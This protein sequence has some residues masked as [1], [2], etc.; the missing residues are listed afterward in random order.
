MASSSNSASGKSRPDAQTQI[1]ALARRAVKSVSEKKDGRSALC[2]ASCVA[3]AESLCRA[4]IELDGG[5]ADAVLAELTG[6]GFG[7]DELAGRIIPQAARRLGEMW[8][9]DEVTFPEV[10]MAA[11]RMQAMI[12]DLFDDNAGS[13][14]DAPRVALIVSTAE[15]HTLGAIVVTG[16]MRRVGV[17]V[18]LCLGRPVAE[19][20]AMLAGSDVDL[21]MISAASLEALPETGRVLRM[22]REELKLDVP[23][24]VG[25][26]VL[27]YA[28]SGQGLELADLVTIDPMDALMRFGLVSGRSRAEA[29]P[30]TG[31]GQPQGPG[32]ALPGDNPGLPVQ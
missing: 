31:Q 13:E 29:A 20:R 12:R 25:G 3:A 14:P 4:A 7:I 2:D 23:L 11:A 18:D 10:S 32:G 19:I 16:M 22:I 9:E 17:Q 26:P 28:R 30:E 27:D 1:V 15:T 8:M 21:V 6:Q 24:V 5:A